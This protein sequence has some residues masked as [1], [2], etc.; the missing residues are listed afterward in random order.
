MRHGQDDPKGGLAAKDLRLL[1][2]TVC[3][4]ESL[5]RVL[6]RGA[7]LQPALPAA[8]QGVGHGRVGVKPAL[9]K[10]SVKGHIGGSWALGGA[11]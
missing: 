8:A 1:R 7:L 4:A 10:L 11:R 9:H 3:L 2:A 5:E 6:G